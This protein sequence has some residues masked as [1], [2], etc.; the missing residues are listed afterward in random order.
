MRE[1]LSTGFRPRSPKAVSRWPKSLKLMTAP[2]RCSALEVLQG[3]ESLKPTIRFGI[4][5]AQPCLRHAVQTR[6][7]RTNKL[8]RTAEKG[9]KRPFA[10]DHTNGCSYP[11]GCALGILLGEGFSPFFEDKV[12]GWASGLSAC[13]SGLC[14]AWPPSPCW[15]GEL[16]LWCGGPSHRLSAHSHETWT[17]SRTDRLSL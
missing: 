7:D 6:T 12:S 1:G 8:W 10:A 2:F 13:S 16:S 5:A 15:H 9:G 4:E 14:L 17:G 11:I 3:N